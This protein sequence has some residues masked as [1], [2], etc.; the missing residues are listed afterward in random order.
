MSELERELDE[1]LRSVKESKANNKA[2]DAE[3][4]KKLDHFGLKG[5]EEGRNL[6]NE[7][8]FSDAVFVYTQIRHQRI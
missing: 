8:R 2:L 7:A 1:L 5:L 6:E 4:L 3:Q